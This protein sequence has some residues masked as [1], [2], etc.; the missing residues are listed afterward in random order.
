MPSPSPTPTPLPHA[1]DAYQYA[2]PIDTTADARLARLDAD[3]GTLVYGLYANQGQSEPVHILPDFSHAGYGGGGVA[4]PG[5]DSI[6]ALVTLSPQAGDDHARIQAA[7]NTVAGQPPDS[8]GIRGAV[9]LQAGTYEVSDTL[10]IDTGGVVLRG[11]GQGPSG[12]IIKATTTT[13]NAELI[14]I[15]GAGSGRNARA[16]ADARRVV[17]TQPYVPVG[18]AQ[19]TV[20]SADGYQVGDAIA[21]ERTPNDAWLGAGGV[22]TAQYGWTTATYNVAYERT[23]TAIE[24][25]TL[26]FDIPLVDTIEDQFGG[27][28]VYRTD[29]SARLQQVGVENLRLE[30]LVYADVTRSDRAFFGLT[31]R[32]VEHSWVRDVT[33]AYFSHGFELRDGARFNTL[34]DIAHLDANFQVTG[35][36]HYGFHISDGQQNLIQRCYGRAL[37]HTFVT[38]SRVQ[39]PNVYL[40]CLAEDTANDDGPHQRW[41]TGVLYDNIRTSL[42]RVQNRTS[43]GSGHGWAGAQNLLW[44]VDTAEWVLQAP[45]GAMN[46]AVGIVGVQILGSFSP[47]EPDGRVDSPGLFVTP[48]SLYLQQLE[49]RLGRQAVVNI[50]VPAQREGTIWADLSAWAGEGEFAP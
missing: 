44:N 20:A 35:G 42:T 17:I 31:M 47:N 46:W 16:A 30:T 5:Y 36:R 38:G 34:Q 10:V 33:A 26:V 50:T 8:R 41:A 24:G 15:I 11:Q 39:G 18:T 22:D 49:D 37:R 23:L 4:L 29:T 25:N 3:S 21:V 27:G 43:S 12:T 40:D 32:D 19:V 9:L 1:S 7:I 28:E 13:A 45:T 14:T 2:R 48:R 6:P